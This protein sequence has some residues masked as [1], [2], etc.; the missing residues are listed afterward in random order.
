MLSSSELRSFFYG[1]L[2]G[3]S[4]IHNGSFCCRQISEDLIYYK[5]NIIKEHIPNCNVKVTERKE[6]IDK[7]G[8][9][10][11]KSWEMYCSPTEYFKKLYTK[12][13]SDRKRSLSK[14][15]INKLTPIG[16]AVWY[17]D[18]GSTVLVQKNNLT[19]GA[20]TRRIQFCTD[21]YTFED[22]VNIII[23]EM[24]QL[25]FNNI[26][27]I[28][29]C[30]RNQFRIQLSVS[31]GQKMFNDIGDYFLKYYPSLLYKLD[32]GYRNDTLLNTTYVSNN[33]LNLYTK[34]SAHPLFVDRMAN[35]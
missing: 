10:H 35:R 13:Y 32:M 21:C 19:G 31:D 2:L 16:L 4:Y 8:I 27:L 23:P 5:A 15:I 26:K 24:E 25:G 9:C 33:Y 6:Y 34:I 12:F 1:T 7:N 17:A 11:Q 14:N 22:N 3:D 30:R 20:K 29:R 18:D 28:D